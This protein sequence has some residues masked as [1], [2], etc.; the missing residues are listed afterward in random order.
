M[1]QAALWS[2]FTLV[3]L[4]V[5]IAIIGVLVALLLP[6]VQAAREAARRSQCTNNMK[7][8]ALGLLN[9]ESAKEKIPGGASYDD[10]SMAAAD[11]TNWE[12]WVVSVLPYIEQAQLFQQIDPKSP[13]KL[14][15]TAGATRNKQLAA[16]T[17]IT[18]LICPLSA[19]RRRRACSGKFVGFCHCPA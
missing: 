7:Q 10:R 11:R 19:E 14:L 16:T 2:G 15:S 5:V 13:F 6:A 4:L 17:V 3:E 8:T 1:A 9:Y 12:R 18:S